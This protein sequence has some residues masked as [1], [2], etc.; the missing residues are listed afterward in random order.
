[1][2]KSARVP[3]SAPWF[4]VRYL[5][6]LMVGAMDSP[7]QWSKLGTRV[8]FPSHLEHPIPQPCE[9]Q[10]QLCPLLHS[11]VVPLVHLQFHGSIH[12]VFGCLPCDLKIMR[13][14]RAGA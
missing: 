11:D 13:R 14:T 8:P 10:K 2:V 5:G 1:M 9:N 4:T 12:P 6:S 3:A 7:G